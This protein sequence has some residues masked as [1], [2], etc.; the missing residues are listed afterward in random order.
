[1]SNNLKRMSIVLMALLIIIL[2]A[3]FYLNNEEITPAPAFT[4]KAS[5]SPSPLWFKK[6]SNSENIRCTMDVIQCPDGSYVGRVAPRCLFAPC[7]RGNK[8]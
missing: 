1:M 7:P 6:P 8:Y 5:P 3:A 4:N 2:L